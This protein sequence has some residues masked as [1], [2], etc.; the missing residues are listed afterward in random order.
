MVAIPLFRVVELNIPDSIV[1]QQRLFIF[2]LGTG[3]MSTKLVAHHSIHSVR[4]YKFTEIWRTT[5]LHRHFCLAVRDTV[6]TVYTDFSNGSGT[7]SIM[8]KE[9]TLEN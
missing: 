6:T 2:Y 8:F 1:N 7:D 3:R 4:F 9:G 5:H